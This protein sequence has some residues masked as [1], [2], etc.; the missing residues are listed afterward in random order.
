MNILNGSN[1]SKR[2]L[3]DILFD[4]IKITL[5][6]GDKIGLAG[7]NGEGKTTLL[8][9]LA[10]IEQPTSGDLSW[11]KN[12]AIGFL[13]QTPQYEA[14]AKVYQCLKSV[15]HSLNEVA[16]QLETIE[17]EMSA[18]P[19]DIERLMT[20]YGELQL[21]FEK[22]GGYEIEAQIRKVASGLNISH[23]LDSEWG[24]LSGG[25]RTKVGIAQI[26]IQST[27]LL[28]LDEPTN[29]LDIKAIEWLT[30][31]IANYE[32]A[33][34]IVSHDR[35][36]L[37][38]TVNQIMEIDQQNL[39]VYEGN[40][41]HF[42]E[43]REKRVLAEFEAYQNQQKKIK[44]MKESIKQLRIWAGQ[45]KPPN[46]AMY[47]RAK[48]MEKALNRIQRL[49][50]PVFEPK[51]MN[52]ELKEGKRVSNKVVEMTHV[53]KCYDDFLY[54]DVN[55]LVRRG[56]H[57]AIIGDNGAGKSTLLKM[58]LGNVHPDEGTVYTAAN[59]KIGY[60]SQHEF[61]DENDDTVLNIFRE[62]V[63]VT[64]GKARH[65]LA[66]FMFYGKD[67]FKKVKDLS[68]GEKVRLRWAQIVNSDYNLLV[69]DEP[70][71]HLDIDSKETI[72]DAL[73]D[74]DG[75]IITVSH[76]RYFLN[77]LFNTT[78]LLKDQ[79]LEKFEGNYEY[80]KSKNAL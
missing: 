73:L 78:Y 3:E 39:H 44:K 14:H 19:D 18:S 17:K 58:I 51:N 10:G 53:A 70:T 71:N 31:Y 41:S 4:H 62:R 61:E 66:N 7:R 79:K 20:R 55:M 80:V 56:E 65:L 1:I 13:D 9:L 60:L 54:D 68:G 2:Y 42:V 24:T 38:E 40:Y 74:Y 26:L 32:G 49:E 77:K 29:H 59:L 47:K 67:V 36:F 23:L 5:N 45:A 22:N 69:L 27:D 46:A 72:E 64:E 16:D 21:Y 30:Q 34:V 43:E 35:Y 50:K 28:I 75:T 15:F 33:V 48:S 11:K 6:A 25:E 57:V 8:R 37:D 12:I 76:D 52:I 63:N